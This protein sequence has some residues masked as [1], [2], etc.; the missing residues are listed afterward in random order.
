MR[1]IL[2]CFLLCCLQCAI[3]AHLEAQ[4][5]GINT[6]GASANHDAM[7]DVSGTAQGVLINRMNSAQMNAIALP[8]PEGLI[9]YNTD[10]KTIE[11]YNGT[12]WTPVI[13][14]TAGVSIV[15][16]PAG[17]M[18]SGTSIT[19]TSIP[20]N[21]GSSPSYLWQVN[22]INTGT[23][24]TNNTYTSTTLNN[25][26]AVTC[27]MT[28]SNLSCVTGSTAMSNAITIAMY[29]TP[30]INSITATACSGTEFN[31]TPADITDGIVPPGTTYSWSAPSVTGNITGGDSG[32]GEINIRGK[33]INPTNTA[34]TATYSVT[35]NA[36]RCSG[37]SFML[38]V[39]V[40][41]TPA[42]NSITATVCNDAAF[43][44]T[45]ANITNGMVPQ[46]TV[47]NWSAPSVTG[48]ITGGYAG[49][50]A[51]NIS[52]TLNN[53]TYPV[54]KAIYTISPTAGI[55]SG[56]NF[57]LNL[58]VKSSSMSY[59]VQTVTINNSQSS[60]TPTIFQLMLRVNTSSLITARHMRNDCGDIIFA[61]SDSTTLLNSWI[62]SGINSASTLI[63]VKVPSSIPANS[64]KTIYMY[65]GNVSST[66]DGNYSGEAPQISISYGQYDNGANVFSYFDNFSG[67]SLSGKWSVNG[68]TY[69][70]NNGFTATAT[71]VE[72]GYI[73]DNSYNV[74]SG[75]IVDFY[76]QTYQSGGWVDV[77]IGT[78]YSGTNVP[79]LA[80]S[81]GGT[82]GEGQECGP[83]GIVGSN[84]NGNSVSCTMNPFATGPTT[85]IWSIYAQATF[86]IYLENYANP[87]AVSGS[88]PSYPLHPALI[89]ANAG[90][91][92]YVYTDPETVQW[93]RI[94]NAPPNNIMPVVS[95]GIE[96][97]S[98]P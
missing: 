87:Q 23:N 22:G 82:T 52:G 5:V 69:S 58:T 91:F 20:I 92:Y 43:N 97:L 80:I 68:I 42:I 30:A 75:S 62:E 44:I 79:H 27:I 41:P 16:S 6:T 54:Q 96:Q 31:K 21:G 93:Y 14:I 60:S 72:P 98:C 1:K 63:W 47:Y 64:S 45:P 13:S 38:T 81:G 7:L 51:V 90:N 2:F 78:A 40:N 33:L 15:S 28:P 89:Q 29:Q 8:I 76:G 3:C 35:P 61:D 50:N 26:D 95:F 88:M 94:R 24:S 46:G 48:N 71:T 25:G 19:F 55:C 18:C 70:V 34:Q 65:Y 39:T 49:I 11:Y 57:T 10:C 32:I 4:G 9:I 86:A 56:N 53:P 36:G 66:F 17:I 37:N 77:G 73:V 85:D 84:R 59:Y 12:I 83:A 67:N 74:Y